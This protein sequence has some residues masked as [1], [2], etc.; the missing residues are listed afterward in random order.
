[1]KVLI[2]SSNTLPAAPSGPAYIAG[3]AR[4]AGYRLHVFERLVAHDLE[5]EL[6][7]TLQDFQPDIIGLSIHLVFGD[8]LNPQAPLGTRH[9]DLRPQVKEIVD[10]IH[11]VSKA[12][13]VLRCPGFNY[14]AT[15]WLKYLG[16]NYGIR[17]DNPVQPNPRIHFG[18][19]D[20]M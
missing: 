19:F 12:F 10:I 16:L 20:C 7:E 9:T 1:M 6:T 14:Y 3:A 13:V 8:E 4:Q 17:G 2:I 18:G 11:Q 5:A 15:D